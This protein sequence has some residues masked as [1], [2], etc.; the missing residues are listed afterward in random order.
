MCTCLYEYMNPILLNFTISNCQFYNNSAGLH[1]G[2]IANQMANSLIYNNVFDGNRAETNI[3]GTLLMKENGASNTV[4]DHCYIYNSYCGVASSWGAG[5]G[6]ISI[7]PGD[8]NITIS[9]CAIINSTANHT[10]GGAISIRSPA[11]LSLDAATSIEAPTTLGTVTYSFCPS[12]FLG[13]CIY[14]STFSSTSPA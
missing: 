2:A 7:G 14:C 8:K 9:N 1:G 12:D 5:G 3:G 4:V 6:A 10:Y 11:C 13:T